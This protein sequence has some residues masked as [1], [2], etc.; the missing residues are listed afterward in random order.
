MQVEILPEEIQSYLA[1]VRNKN[2]KRVRDLMP[3]ALQAFPRYKPDILDIQD[4]YALAL[5]KL[6]PRYTQKC[7]LVLQEP[8]TDEMILKKIKQAIRRVKK[9]PNHA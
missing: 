2:E 3:L 6:K 4:I 8:I 7:S 1:T 5:N 9:Y